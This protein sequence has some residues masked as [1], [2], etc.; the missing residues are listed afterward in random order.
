M[1]KNRKPIR[2]YLKQ[3]KRIVN[4]LYKKGFIKE[5]KVEDFYWESYKICGS[6]KPRKRGKWKNKEKYRIII[7][8]PQVFFGY[9]DYFG[10]WDD[11]S[12]VDRVLEELYWQH[13]YKDEDQEDTDFPKSTFKIK[14]RIKIIKYLE[15]LP[16]VNSDNKIK[17]TTRYRKEY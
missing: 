6:K 13:A 17:K 9:C 1:A 5:H 7:Y 3:E 8:Y 11:I 16:T 14:D 10:E 15:K 2:K 4:L 12:I